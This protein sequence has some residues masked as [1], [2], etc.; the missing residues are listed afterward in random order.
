MHIY[1][2]LESGYLTSKDAITGRHWTW[3]GRRIVSLNQGMVGGSLGYGATSA[4]LMAALCYGTG[5]VWVPLLTV[6]PCFALVSWN[7]ERWELPS[8]LCLSLGSWRERKQVLEGGSAAL[9]VRPL[10]FCDWSFRFFCFGKKAFVIAIL[11]LRRWYIHTKKLNYIESIRR[12]GRGKALFLC[13]LICF[14]SWLFLMY[15]LEISDQIWAH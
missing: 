4:S 10:L 7:Q 11:Y 8:P 1:L 3:R 2:H 9:T 5:A 15:P 14:I 6:V 13:V 12:W